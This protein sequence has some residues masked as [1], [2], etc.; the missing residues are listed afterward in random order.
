MKTILDRHM[1]SR[2][3]W[4]LRQFSTYYDQFHFEKPTIMKKAVHI[5]TTNDAET[6]ISRNLAPQD[7]KM[8]DEYELSHLV[9]A[10]FNYGKYNTQ[11]QLSESDM[12]Y[13]KQVSSSY[14]NS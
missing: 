2:G 1:Q 14:F 6:V 8:D 3:Q 11:D 7:Y 12:Q 4:Q 13:V 10:A 9:F 5:S